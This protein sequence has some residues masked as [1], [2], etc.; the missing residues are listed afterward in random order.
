MTTVNVRDR[1]AGR[2]AEIPVKP[3]TN[4]AGSDKT[5]NDEVDK[6]KGDDDAIFQ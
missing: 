5:D 3:R 2:S 1:R 4:A 6:N